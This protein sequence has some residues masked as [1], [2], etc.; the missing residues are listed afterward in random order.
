[1]GPRIRDHITHK[2]VLGFGSR[3]PLEKVHDAVGVNE[4]VVVAFEDE[5]GAGATCLDPLQEKNFFDSQIE[6]RI[7]EIPL[8]DVFMAGVLKMQHTR[9]IWVVVSRCCVTKEENGNHC[10]IG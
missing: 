9:Q 6:K 8:D 10:P 3:E 7:T 2:Q 1:M 5:L 4:D